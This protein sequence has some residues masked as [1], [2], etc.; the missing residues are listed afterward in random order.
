MGKSDSGREFFFDKQGCWVSYL[1]LYPAV[2]GSFEIEITHLSLHAP[3][4]S[5]VLSRKKL[6]TIGKIDDNVLQYIET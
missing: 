3:K 4:D 6:T 5:P 1:H 2:E